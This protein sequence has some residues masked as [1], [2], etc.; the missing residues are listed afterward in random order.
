ML[1]RIHS[2][3]LLL[4]LLIG[5]AGMNYVQAANVTLTVTAS[6]AAGG[7]VRIA[8]GAWTT[9]TNGTTS[10]SV[11]QST[12]MNISAQAASGY[13]FSQWNDGNTSANRPVQITKNTTYT[14]TFIPNTVTLTVTSNNTNYGTVTG[15][16]TYDYGTSVTIKATPKT[17]YHF[18]QWS[19]GNTTASRSITATANA[20]YTATFAINQYTLTVK[21]AAN[22]TT[23]G[24][25]KINSGTAGASAS[26]TINHGSS[27]TITATPATGYHFVQWNDGNTTASRSVTVTAA[28]TY[29]ATFAVNQYTLTVKTATNNTTQG[30][31]KIGSGTA[32][33]SA[34]A[35]INH[36]STATITATPK[37]G[38]HFVK[39]NDNNTTASRSVTVTAAATYTATFAINTYTIT[40][41]SNNSEMGYAQMTYIDP[42]SQGTSTYA[43]TSHAFNYGDQLTLTAYPSDCAHFVKWSDNSTEK[44]RT[45]TVTGTKTYTATFAA[46]TYSG[47]CG[48]TGNEA[49]VQWSLNMCTGTLSITGTGDMMN[50][51]GTDTP[52][53]PYRGFITSVTISNS[54]TSIGNYAFYYCS[55]MK[56]VS[57][58]TGVTSIGDYAFYECNNLTSITIGNHVTSIGSRAFLNCSRLTSITIP[59]SVTSISS[60]AFTG[61]YAMESLYITNLAA[62]CNISFGASSASPF[63][64]N[65]FTDHIG[66]GNLY[67]NG[68]K[69]TT[70]T[71]PNGIT[72]IPNYAFFGFAGITDIQ[73][74]QTKTIGDFA[75]SCCLG[76]TNVTIP[77]GV[78]T[79]GNNAF[80]YCPHML[81]MS[82]PVSVT[83]LGS[84]MMYN[85]QALTDIYAH[86]TEN[87]PAWPSS[88]TS[89]TPQSDITLHVPTCMHTQY[90]GGWAGY[91]IDCETED[92]AVSI[93]SNNATYGLVQYNDET[94]IALIDKQVPCTT[95]FAVTAVPAEGC[96]F[97]EWSD[98]LLQKTRTLGNLENDTAL[99]ALFGLGVPLEIY[100]DQGGTPLEGALHGA[101]SVSATQVVYFSQGP[102]QFNSTLGT[103]ECADGT[104]KPGTWRFAA[105][106]YDVVGDM[107]VGNVYENGIKCSNTKAS[108]TYT[109]WQDMYCW[110]ASGY[111]G[112]EPYKANRPSTTSIAGTNYDWGVYNAISNG[113]NTPGL[114][115]TPTRAEWN[116]MFTQRPNALELNAPA[117]VE[118]MYGLVVLPDDW[119][120]PA[121]LSLVTTSTQYYTDNVF[122]AAQWQQMENAGAVFIP[123]GGWFSWNSSMWISY[124]RNTG[125]LWASTGSSTSSQHDVQWGSDRQA[126]LSASSNH[127]L[128]QL[129]LVSDVGGYT[130]VRF[131]GIDSHGDKFVIAYIYVPNGATP[132]PPE[133]P[134]RECYTFTGWDQSI[135]PANGHVTTYTAQ[136]EDLIYSGTCGASGDNL[137]WT[138]NACDSTLTISGTG[139]MADYSA[140]GAPWNEY[141]DAI[142]TV[143]FADGINTIGENAFAGFTNLTDIYAPWTENIPVL[144][145]SNN[146][147]PS[148]KLHI[149]CSAISDYQAAGW[150]NYTVETEYTASGTCGAQG[151]NVTWTYCDGVLTISGTGAMKNYTYADAN[152]VPWYS[153]RTYNITS[154]VIEE[155]V[156]GIGDYVFFACS[157]VT[158][159]TIPNS[160]TS[161][162]NAAFRNCSSLAS[163]TIPE[164]V[165]TIGNLAFYSCPALTSIT[166]PNSVTSIG[167]AALNYCSALEDIY[168]SWTENIPTWISMTNRDQQSDINLHVPCGSKSGYEAANGWKDYT[169]KA[170]I[171][172]VKSGTYGPDNIEWTFDY[173]D[174]LLTITGNGELHCDEN[175][176]GPNAG[177]INPNAVKYVFIGK[178]V[179]YLGIYTLSYMTNIEYIEIEEGHPTHRTG[180]NAIIRIG[181]EQEGDT[182]IFGCPHTVIPTTCTTI[183]GYGFSDNHRVTEMTI[184]S[185]VKQIA[186]MQGS[187]WEGNNGQVFYTS[188]SASEGL[189]DLYVEWT[190][191]ED[192][193]AVPNNRLGDMTKVRLHVPC[194]TTS[195]YK[196]VTGWS[197]F[198]EYIEESATFTIT[199]QSADPT[200]GDVSIIVN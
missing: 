159:V 135:A 82:I 114:W 29:T 60:S 117:V 190:Q 179:T 70:L 173:C 188:N 187:L 169:L 18:V 163:I 32:G 131:V 164:T 146:P 167:N 10:R 160:V 138:L 180:C 63:F 9:S 104:T 174:S 128:E 152:T 59:P 177:G 91:T 103:H 154:I 22:N 125:E 2:I 185:S 69:V 41:A 155:G 51:S 45:V 71:I 3:L 16:G 194:G 46:D 84:L 37:T 142:H 162:G 50:Y 19:D 118:G 6:P 132:V 92:R 200:M 145:A 186:N 199:V 192:I 42:V 81:S 123:S 33:A 151:S 181:S 88:F 99:T 176:W 183:R 40:V 49:N 141:K 101:F 139:A 58:G 78:T 122:T 156:T 196:Q 75:F 137:T 158:S 56:S 119:D 5:G 72:E 105:N 30:T 191:L 130:K 36:G 115:R 12:P 111:N 153:F 98:G 55:N 21:T 165:L 68:T 57:M 43:N 76:L 62:W 38:Y 73:F 171:P 54:V 106:Q 195:L 134:E 1:R 189:K 113:G 23:Q 15:G 28:K 198:K 48:A 100:D 102:L 87:V 67:V 136:Y 95:T 124:F 112:I 77:E 14:A 182:L 178:G 89:K 53:Y 17:G 116:Y 39:W 168:V 27:A 94:P 34:S 20:S 11:P 93:A 121:G 52:W 148:V 35:T 61:C 126:Y 25:V 127:V 97:V 85:C 143:T 133:V 13:R 66:G 175:T 4:A 26:A 170:D 109:G 86:W 79:I 140:G 7:Q 166:F 24:T 161:I 197:K 96:H 172:N 80:A 150:G 120:P 108:A 65:D 184:P 110:G 149:A 47:T 44:T 8:N 107:S 83:S 64:R 74:N 157:S 129:R 193:P 144:P 90:T 31:V 147:Q